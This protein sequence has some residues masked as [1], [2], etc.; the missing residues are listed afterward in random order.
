LL[1]LAG[2]ALRNDPSSSL[3]VMWG[4]RMQHADNER[5][6]NELFQNRTSSF[7]EEM[8]PESTEF[9]RLSIRV[10]HIRLNHI[11]PNVK[12]AYIL[13]VSGNAAF[14][15]DPDFCLMFLRAESF[16]CQKAAQ[17]MVNHFAFKLQLWG[18]ELLGKRITIAD[19][20]DETR[21]ALFHEQ[22]NTT[23]VLPVR[24]AAGRAVFCTLAKK[25]D[26]SD[27][28]NENASENEQSHPPK[29]SAALIMSRMMWYCFMAVLEDDAETQR[30]GITHIYHYDGLASTSSQSESLTDANEIQGRYEAFSLFIPARVLNVR[31]STWNLRR[32]EIQECKDAMMKLG[33]PPIHHLPFQVMPDQNG[34]EVVTI[35]NRFF[36]K[37]LNVRK[38][39]EKELHKN[40]YKNNI[41][42][43]RRDDVVVGTGTVYQQ[44]AGNVTFR[45]ILYDSMADYRSLDQRTENAPAKK[46]G[47]VGEMKKKFI[48]RL[49]AKLKGCPYRMRF[50]KKV[51]D[52]VWDE[53]PHH[54]VLRK[55]QFGFNRMAA[56]YRAERT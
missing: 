24:D 19:L 11:E 51:D 22:N 34:K 44:H 28:E 12:T 7:N 46:K 8:L 38:K 3:P 37:W 1:L 49:L 56:K 10:L 25:I 6:W 9:V 55:I 26:D 31:I 39:I 14:V 16:D 47:T 23:Q 27:L 4:E 50:V 42:L 20:D 21:H 2:A 48:E 40:K 36:R 41:K 45:T 13:A 53:A 30:N 35:E 54:T 5:K 33:I 43:L 18:K 32:P 15:R 17:R 29:R 52:G